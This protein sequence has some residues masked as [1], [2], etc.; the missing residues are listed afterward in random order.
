[1]TRNA[2]LIMLPST[3]G[4]TLALLVV[5]RQ[6]TGT[7]HLFKVHNRII[8]QHLALCHNVEMISVPEVIVTTGKFSAYTG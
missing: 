8:A 7:G 1:M 3:S 6:R 2:C 4:C 5:G